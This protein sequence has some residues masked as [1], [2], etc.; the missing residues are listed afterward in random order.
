MS[1]LAKSEVLLGLVTLLT[2]LLYVLGVFGP[3][4]SIVVTW[5]LLALIIGG[6][7]VFLGINKN[8]VSDFVKMA[9]VFFLV[10]I[11]APVIFL[12]FTFNGSGIS[13]G[14]PPS[15]F[16]AHW[17]FATP[18][19]VISLIGIVVIGSLFKRNTT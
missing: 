5:G 13:D 2:G 15:N 1:N 19:L 8:G 14:T 11:Q 7:V 18:H 6:I 9:I 4:E 16:V 3:T 17:I 10:L 12:W